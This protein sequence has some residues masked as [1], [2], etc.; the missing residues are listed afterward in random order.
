MLAL[1]GMRVTEYDLIESSNTVQTYGVRVERNLRVQTLGV[2][3][4][5]NILFSANS[6]A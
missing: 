5:S 6:I 4:V 2:A 3:R 1:S